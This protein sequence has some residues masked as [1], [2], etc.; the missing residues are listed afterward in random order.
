M[1]HFAPDAPILHTCATLTNSSAIKVILAN[2]VDVGAKDGYGA[3]AV[4]WAALSNNVEGIKFLVAASCDPTERNMIGY[5]PYI[6]ASAAGYREA[7]RELLQ[8]ASRQD[9]DVAMAR[10][11]R[12]GLCQA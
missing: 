4:L 6:M 5:T 2:R 10:V 9:M 11:A 12:Q 3:T 7:M 8:G 1:C